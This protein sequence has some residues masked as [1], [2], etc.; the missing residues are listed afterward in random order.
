MVPK[1]TNTLFFSLRRFLFTL[2]FHSFSVLLSL[3]QP[4]LFVLCLWD[5]SWGQR[6]TE[7]TEWCIVSS[8]WSINLPSKVFG[9]TTYRRSPSFLHSDFIIRVTIVTGVEEW[10][11]NVGLATRLA[12]LLSCISTGLFLLVTLTLIW[13]T[14]NSSKIKHL[15]MKAQTPVVETVFNISWHSYFLEF[16]WKLRQE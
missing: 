13:W 6:D 2:F 14:R 16:V 11:V 10:L 9:Q 3:E 5:H 1:I 12:L 8:S 4:L 7:M 15:K